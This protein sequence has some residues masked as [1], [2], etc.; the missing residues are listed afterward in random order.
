MNEW[1][2]GGSA[3]RGVS[4]Q[5]KRGI[6]EYL[7]SN[8]KHKCQKC[9]WGKRHPQDGRTTLHIHHIDGDAHNS[10]P[11]NLSVLC[12]NCHSLTDNHGARNKLSA[13]VY[14]RKSDK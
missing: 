12:P 8:A 13:R 4:L 6:R 14:R 5:M 7:L 10:N 1:L 11:N 2:A 9:G 3:V